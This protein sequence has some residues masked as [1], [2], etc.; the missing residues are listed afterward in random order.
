MAR[1]VFYYHLKKLSWE[2]KYASAR[3]EIREIFTTHKGRYGY[4]RVTAEMHN[5]NHPINHKTVYRLM[6]EMGLWDKKRKVHYQSY[7]GPLGKEAPNLINR[8]F[9]AGAPNQKWATDITQINIGGEKLYFSPILDMFNGEIIAYD[10]ST[11]PNLEQVYAMLERAFCS[12]KALKGLILHSDQGRQY[13]YQGYRKRPEEQGIVQSVS[14]KANCFDN[15][16]MESFFGTMKTELFTSRKA[17]QRLYESTSTT[18][19]ESG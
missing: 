11:S 9:S 19:I 7:L 12:R 1:S 16:M 17:L 6:R 8:S 10:L 3:A 14:R 15:A 13:R 4:R 5:R 2:D 18:T